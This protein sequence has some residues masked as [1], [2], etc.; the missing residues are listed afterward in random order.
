ML[1]WRGHRC[2][3]GGI[4]AQAGAVPQGYRNRPGR[5]ATNALRSHA[6]RFPVNTNEL[7][8]FAGETFNGSLT[9]FNDL[10]IY[11]AA[12]DNSRCV[13]SPNSPL[14]RSGHWICATQHAGGTLWLFGGEFSSPKQNTFYNCN[15]F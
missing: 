2:C 10:N 6:R 1:F 12:T 7:F 5:S 9:T 8:L 4:R 14:P 15:D 13:T 3:S 11:N